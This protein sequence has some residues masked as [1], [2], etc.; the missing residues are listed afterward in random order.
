MNELSE[1][2][3]EIRIKEKFTSSD[4][5]KNIVSY[6]L[7]LKCP[8]DLSPSKARTLKLHV[9]KYCIFESQLY[10]KDPLG[11]LLVCLVEYETEKVISE[12]HEGVCGGHHAWRAVAYKILRAGY[13]WPKLFSDVN[14]KVR[15]CN[16]CQLFMGKHKLPALPLVLVKT[17]APF[18]QWGLDF[19]GKINPHSS[20]QQKWILTATDYFT[21]WVEAIPTRRETDS[22]VIY[23][24]EEI[25]LSRFG[26]PRKIVTDNAQDFKS[27]AMISFFQNYNIV[28][29]HSTAYYPQGNGLVES[30]NK[31]LINIIKKVLNENKKSWHVH[32]KYALWENRIGTKKSI[33]TSPFQMVYR[34]D[35]VLPINLSLPVMKLWQDEK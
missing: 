22:M 15:A 35:M 23:F 26:C 4:W 18:Q 14:A 17:G 24:L 32:L 12:F 3:S 6:L 13:Y 30:S 27:M 2:T 1:K 21:K 20:A 9:V 34:T 19:I 31:S 8:S 11:F 16:P 7:T 25:I 10:W 29:S 28:L 33:G 5:Y